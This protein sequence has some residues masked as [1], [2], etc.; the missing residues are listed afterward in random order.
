MC[1]SVF[2]ALDRQWA[3]LVHSPDADGALARWRA[4]LEF[5]PADLDSLVTAIQGAPAPA[6][7]AALLVL[8]R[9]A[10]A[11]GVAARTL[12]QALRPGLLK[13]GQNLAGRGS[14]DEVDHEIVALAWE[15]I[16]TYPADRRPNAVAKNVLL[17]VR[18][19]YVLGAKRATAASH[20]LLDQ[21]HPIDD[22]LPPTRSAE[23][24]TLDADVASLRRAHAQLAE[25]VARSA[26]TPLSA[27][28]VW[29]TRVQQF[30]DAE[31]A[32]ELGMAV[33]SV[34]RR[35][36]RAERELAFAS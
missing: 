2:D 26:I 17:D 3:D 9:W 5:D 28:V 34:Q 27:R 15:R 36:Q 7:N 18:K 30:D 13:L 10:P 23:D 14:F 1:R 22:Q 19:R 31:V 21:L 33:R 35:R 25:A 20:E 12:L 8:A 32:A 16:R 4:E 24:E 11:D 29:R 6:A